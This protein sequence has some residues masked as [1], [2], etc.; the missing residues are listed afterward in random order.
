MVPP[1]RRYGIAI[2]TADKLPILHAAAL[3]ACD[4]AVAVYDGGGNPNEASS[5]EPSSAGDE[6]RLPAWLGEK[7]FTSGDELWCRAQQKALQ[8]VRHARTG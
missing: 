1:F 5:F 4:A 3:E 6:P 2:L 8:C 7:F